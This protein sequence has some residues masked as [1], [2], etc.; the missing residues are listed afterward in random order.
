VRSFWIN[1]EAAEVDFAESTVSANNPLSYT[2]ST[3]EAPTSSGWQTTTVPYFYRLV[4][5]GQFY[6]NAVHLRRSLMRKVLFDFL[7]VSGIG[8]LVIYLWQG[9]LLK[10]VDGVTVAPVEQ[11]GP[12]ADDIWQAAKAGF[13]LAAVRSS[14]TLENRY[15]SDSLLKLTVTRGDE[16]IGWFVCLGKH[17]K[18]HPQFGR[19]RIV[20]IVDCLTLP[21]EEETCVGA[22]IRFLRG[23]EIDMVVSHQSHAAYGEAM[24]ANG[25]R[26]AP[27]RLTLALSPELAKRLQPLEDMASRF[28]FAT[29]DSDNLL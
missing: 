21:G 23:L 11:F 3:G 28:H 20:T 1:G 4:R 22:A 14:E 24:T 5:P 17:W 25:M 7:A 12:C 9:R 29:G 16:T 19:M 27:S 13:I 2:L 8:H 6:R 18:N 15:A 26:S 10:A